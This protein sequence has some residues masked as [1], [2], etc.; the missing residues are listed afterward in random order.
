V[1]SQSLAGASGGF[2]PIHYLGNKTRFL[3]HIEAAVDE[4]RRSDGAA[5]DLF[6]GTGV[7]SRAL[8]SK[9]PVLSVDIQE[10]SKVLVRALTS[11]SGLDDA[12]LRDLAS[13]VLEHVDR[14][15]QP[16]QELFEYEQRALQTLGAERLANLLEAGSLTVG[17]PTD[18]EFAALHEAARQ[19]VSRLPGSQ[20]LLRYYGGVYFSYR[21]AAELDG[22]LSFIRRFTEA[23]NLNTGLAAVLGAASDLTSTVGNHFAQPVR[24]R[25][26][27]GELKPGWPSRLCKVRRI[28]ALDRATEWATRYRELS[29]STHT[30]TPV[31]GDYR[32]VLSTIGLGEIGVIYADPPY[33]RDHYSRFYHVLET[34]ALGDDPGVSFGPGSI[35]GPSRGLY[36]IRRHQSPFSIRSQVV[37]AFSELFWQARRLDAPLVLSYSPSGAGTAARP[38]PRLLTVPQVVELARDFFRDVTLVETDRVAHSKLN[39]RHLNGEVD[40]DAEILLL[41]RP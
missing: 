21:Q 16:L 28:S 40:Y 17:R 22:L 11:P 35:D 39:S 5:I 9:Q 19:S 18:L 14:L 27:G 41:A 31:R 20:I 30:C 4:V 10:Y 26:L 24:P 15:P 2:R 38:K 36:R 1:F 25:G 23:D 32:D 33:T 6:A 3:T 34:I 29:G 13:S 8:A 37:S 12:L 7:V